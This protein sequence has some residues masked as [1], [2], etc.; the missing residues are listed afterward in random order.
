MPA[1]TQPPPPFS[2]TQHA[3]P[4]SHP[5]T[6]TPTSSTSKG[7]DANAAAHPNLQDGRNDFGC[8]FIHS[9]LDDYGL[10]PQEFRVYC[11]IARRAS[12]GQAWPSV[13]NIARVC[14]IHPQTAR[15]ALR[16]L[17]EHCLI[18]REDRPGKSAL[19]RLTPS[20]SWSPPTHITGQTITQTRTSPPK[21]GIPVPNSH[22]TPTKVIQGTPTK[23]IQGTPTKAIQGYPYEKD[24]D[25][26]T[27]IEGT[28][29]KE[30]PHSPPEGESVSC[31]SSDSLLAEEIY[32]AYPRKVGRPAALC[33]IRRALAADSPAYLLERTR[34]YAE[35]YRGDSRYIPHPATWYNQ[36][37]FKDDPETWRGS[38]SGKA[39]P[40]I[41]RASDHFTGSSIL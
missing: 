20:S 5:T 9:L 13:A 14:L 17:A 8:V 22:P 28:P 35:T 12:S 41:S 4:N 31:P 19:Y 26:G 33:A 36:E 24:V 2:E 34:L 32:G 7:H 29:M 18:V 10:A 15:R 27:P 40:A 30:Y 1:Q 16:V 6:T 37:R 23:A 25:E 39:P 11:H 3:P 21:A 38:T